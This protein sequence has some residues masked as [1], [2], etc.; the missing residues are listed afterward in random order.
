MLLPWA[1]MYLD[2]TPTKHKN[3]KTSRRILLRE[4]YR[5]NGKVNKR[6]IANLSQFPDHVIDAIDKALKSGVT[7][8]VYADDTSILARLN[9]EQGLA[10]G[11]VHTLFKVRKHST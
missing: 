7:P 4:S 3:G 9:A 11:A 1:N 10:V 5:K 6:T 8:E 2:K